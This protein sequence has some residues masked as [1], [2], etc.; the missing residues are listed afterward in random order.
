MLFR[1]DIN[2]LRAF[3]V[4][5]VVLFH[6]NAQWLTSGFSGV[7]IFFVISGYLMTAII[8]TKMD[9][10][11]F[12][13]WAFYQS[14]A[15]RIVPP[16]ALLCLTLIIFGWFY[17]YSADF[18]ALA[19]HAL[20]SITFLSN[21]VYANEDGYFTAAVT[22]KWL[23]YTWSLSVEWQF[24]IIYP[25]VILGLKKCMQPALVLCFLIAITLMSFLLALYGSL[26]FPDKAFFHLPTRAWELLIGGLI[27]LYP[28]TLSK[29]NKHIAST[30]GLVLILFS[31]LYLAETDLW[32][33]YLTLL[34]ILGASLVLIANNQG[35]A[36]LN[37]A[38]AQRLGSASYSIYLWHWPVYVYLYH[39][40]LA[41]EP[42]MLFAG[43]IGSLLL[44]WASYYFIEQ[45]SKRAAL[46]LF[47]PKPVYLCLPIIMISATIYSFNGVNLWI[48]P[49]SQSPQAEFIASNKNI[50]LAGSYYDQCNAYKSLK[51]RHN[52]DI[53]PECMA[54]NGKSGVFLWG[55]SH[56]QALS[57]GIR[58]Y[59]P[60]EVEFYQVASSGCKPSLVDKGLTS[61][62]GLACDSSNRLALQSSLR[63]SFWRKQSCMN[64]LTGM[65]CKRF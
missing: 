45:Y 16:L 62:I 23:L 10:N 47:M 8:F 63:L 18:K 35:S 50:D 9:N 39:Q 38:L 14:R 21:F 59:L 42:S 64:K 29:I 61:T 40:G 1:K 17:L 4:I 30:F 43:M 15:K 33:S 22:E 41:H 20:T 24:Y 25:L 19:K 36:I 11:Q 26:H 32:P 52:T 7:D 46:K 48:R 31:Y 3:A 49:L 28:V 44:G 12:S 53:A 54:S 2:G 5:G 65:T 56:A 27:F 60:K 58:T 57:L 34:P 37:N 55:D 13:L 51:S 6:F